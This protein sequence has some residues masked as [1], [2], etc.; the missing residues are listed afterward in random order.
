VQVSVHRLYMGTGVSPERFI[1]TGVGPE[2]FIGT[3]VVHR[4][5]I[6]TGVSPQSV[7]R[8]RCQSAEGS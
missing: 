7:H 1:G 8:Y 2:R 4:V 5:F 3:G 6:G